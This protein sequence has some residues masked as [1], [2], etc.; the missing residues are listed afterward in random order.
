MKKD[1]IVTKRSRTVANLGRKE[2]RA[3]PVAR[4]KRPPWDRQGI[5]ELQ[6]A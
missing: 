6:I 4:Y 1:A 5:D 3:A 2:M